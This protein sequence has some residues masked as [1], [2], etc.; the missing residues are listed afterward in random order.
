MLQRMTWD[1]ICQDDDLRGRW[2]A[3]DDCLFDESTGDATEG[4]V[5]D[6]DPDLAELCSRMRESEHTN[7]SIV[8]ADAE[9]RSSAGKK[10]LAN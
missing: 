5:I 8:F 3:I 7:C 4:M 1:E 2:I 6:C 10:T 9:T